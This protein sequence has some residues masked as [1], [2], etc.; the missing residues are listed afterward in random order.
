MWKAKRKIVLKPKAERT[1]KKAG[2]TV[3]KNQQ[4]KVEAPKVEKSQ[5]MWEIVG[6]WTKTVVTKP[7]WRIKFEAQQSTF[8]MFKL[9]EDIRRYLLNKG[10]GTNVWKR[11]KEWLERHWA[12]M[13]M[14]EKLKRFLSGQI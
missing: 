2:T 3:A 13:E 14:I 1:E 10:F 11:D 4:K 9:P 12:D 8:P 7:V 5:S 6:M